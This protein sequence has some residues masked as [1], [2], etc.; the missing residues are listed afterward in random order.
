MN[1]LYKYIQKNSKYSDDVNGSIEQIQ[2]S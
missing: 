2:E 1:R